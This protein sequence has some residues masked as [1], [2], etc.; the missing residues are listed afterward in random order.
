MAREHPADRRRRI[1]DAA[2]AVFGERGY[3]ATS[4][5]Q[6][7]AAA[8]ASKETLYSYFGDKAG[9]LRAAL[10]SL[11]AAPDRPAAATPVDATTPPEEFEELLAG[12]AAALVDDLMQPAYL[13]LARIVVAE[14]PRDPALADQFRAAVAE[15]VLGRVAVV[16]HAGEEHGLV[17]PAV[18]IAQAARAFVGSLLT[19][20]LLDGLLRAPDD[21]RRPVTETVRGQVAL[22]HRSIRPADPSVSRPGHDKESS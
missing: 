19:Y 15:R 13:A 22:F 20:V 8:G 21:V 14:T 12:L 11:I 16:L 9:L 1:L 6:I 7:A 5:G 4:T 18:D 3:A 2:I 17:D 10:T